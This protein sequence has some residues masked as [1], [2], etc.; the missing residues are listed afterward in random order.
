MST[1]VTCKVRGW[2]DQPAELEAGERLADMW[3]SGTRSCQVIKYEGHYYVSVGNLFGSQTVR[4]PSADEAFKI[5]DWSNALGCQ[6]RPRASDVK[7]AH[8]TWEFF[9]DGEWK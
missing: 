7:K 4:A 3:V 2:E 8:P 6:P 5:I 1:S 9:I